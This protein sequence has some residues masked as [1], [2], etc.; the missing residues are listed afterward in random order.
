MVQIGYW[1]SSGI[2]LYQASSK[3]IPSEDDW[4]RMEVTA[5]V[6]SDSTRSEVI[7]YIVASDKGTVYFDCM[8]ME[9]GDCASRY[10]LIENNDFSN[11]STGYTFTGTYVFDQVVDLDSEGS[12]TPTVTVSSGYCTTS[13]L[14][15]RSG[16]GTGYS[17]VASLSLNT[18][19][20][21]L[22]SQTDSSG[23]VWYNVAWASGQ[24]VYY[25]YAS[26]AY[27]SKDNDNVSTQMALINTTSLNV[28]AGAGTGYSAIG[29]VSKD[30]QVQ[31]L[32]TITST[33]SQ[34]WYMIHYTKSGSTYTGCVLAK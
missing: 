8:Q 7:V 14:N 21:I 34:D 9:E 29:T 31:I 1:T 16:A 24:R 28:R 23:T 27:I 25:G 19:V 12:Q 17:V 11:G 22:G 13:A 33:A 2:D 5:A 10:N 3:L 18:R 20:Y 4:Y 26:S 30:T 32:E 6:P 15:V